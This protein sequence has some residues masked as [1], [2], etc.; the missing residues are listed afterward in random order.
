MFY[1]IF[2]NYLMSQRFLSDLYFSANVCNRALSN[3]RVILSRFGATTLSIKTLSIMT[4]SIMTFSV[5]V[6]KI[7]HS[8]E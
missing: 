6:N 2:R 8:T 7:R 4:L 1:N 5:I 3:N